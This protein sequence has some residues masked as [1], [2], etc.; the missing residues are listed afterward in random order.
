VASVTVRDAASVDG[1]IDVMMQHAE[2]VGS[3]FSLI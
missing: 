3:M 1:R 2:A